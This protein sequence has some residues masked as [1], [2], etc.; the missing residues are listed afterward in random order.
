MLIWVA[1]A[2]IA[3]GTASMISCLISGVSRGQ[4]KPTWA[5]ERLQPQ[6]SS[7]AWLTPASTTP[8]E[9]QI[10]AWVGELVGSTVTRVQMFRRIGAA[11]D[12]MKRLRAFRTPDRWA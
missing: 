1:L 2:A 12:R 8:T 7:A 4:R 3:P 6:A 9:A 10:A 5:P 11:A